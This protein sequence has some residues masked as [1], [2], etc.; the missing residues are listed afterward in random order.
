MKYIIFE[1]F[2]GRPV[3]FL[4]PQRVDHGDMRDQ[5]PYA[6]VLSAGY[7][8]LKDGV[9]RCYGGSTELAATAASTDA[10]VIAEKFA[11]REGSP[12]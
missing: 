12:A 7:G 1:D 11:P 6:K 5:L 4:F 9:F 10:A 3:P 8:E 2:S